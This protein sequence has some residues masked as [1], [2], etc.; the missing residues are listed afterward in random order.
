ML[1]SI[2]DLFTLISTILGIATDL[3]QA[4]KLQAHVVLLAS[5]EDVAV[6]MYDI[7]QRKLARIS[8]LTLLEP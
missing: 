2:K 6:K 1:A 3:S 7:E 8:A 5:E 4:G